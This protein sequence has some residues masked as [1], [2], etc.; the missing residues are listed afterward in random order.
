MFKL[1][2]SGGYRKASGGSTVPRVNAAQL[3]RVA[4]APVPTRGA[5]V[6][7]TMQEQGQDANTP[8]AQGLEQIYR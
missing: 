7:E 1:T 6:P 3:N 5:W 4:F 8:R 2:G